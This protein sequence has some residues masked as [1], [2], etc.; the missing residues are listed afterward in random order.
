MA[1][2]LFN[3]LILITS[4]AND[5]ET[6]TS[7]FI[8]NFFVYFYL[9]EGIIRI[10]A[11]GFIFPKNSYLSNNWNILDFIIIISSMM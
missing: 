7:I 4:N 1:I 3:S 8:D 2:I 6:D 11:L 9:T 5:E 10:T